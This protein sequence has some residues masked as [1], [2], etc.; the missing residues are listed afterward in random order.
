MLRPILYFAALAAFSLPILAAETPPMPE[1][2]GRNWVLQLEEGVNPEAFALEHGLEYRGPI[3]VAPGMSLFFVPARVAPARAVE[4]EATFVEDTRVTKSLPQTPKLRTVRADPSF[5]DPLY[6]EQWHWRNT[7]QGGGTRYEDANLPDAWA[8]GVTGAGVLIGIV[9]SGALYNHLDLKDRYRSD[10]SYDFRDQDNDPR[11]INSTDSSEHHGTAVAGIA[12]ATAHNNIG[13]L[14]AAPGASFAALRLIPGLIEDWQEADALGYHPQD[15]QIYNN[16]WGPDNDGAIEFDAPS[17]L[18]QEAFKKGAASGRGGLG[19][20][21]VFAGGND[22]EIGDRGDYDGYVSSIYTIGV[23]AVGADGKVAAYSEPA[24]SLLISAPSG[25]KGPGIITTSSVVPNLLN[26]HTRSFGGTSA[27][28]PIVSGVIALML[29]ANPGLTWRDVQHILVRTAS[30]VDTSSPG[31]AVNGAGHTVHHDYGHGRVDAGA[32]VALARRWVNVGPAQSYS[33]GWKRATFSGNLLSTSISFAQQLKVEHV[34]LEVIRAGT[35]DWK[36]LAITLVSPSGTRSLF[37]EPHEG[38]EDGPNSWTFMSTHHWDESLSGVWTVEISYHGS[39][40]ASNRA[41]NL[42]LTAHGT[43]DS[44]ALPVVTQ[45]EHFIR[46]ADIPL[47]VDY[48]AG[49]GD[50]LDL[51]SLDRPRFGELTPGDNQ[52]LYAMDAGHYGEDEFAFLFAGE[53]NNLVWNRFRVLNPLPAAVPDQAVTTPDQE[54]ILDL[55]ANDWDPEQQPLFLSGVSDSRVQIVGGGKVSFQG[56]DSRGWSR[57]SYT[58]TD[59]VDGQT[60]G[61]AKVIYADPTNRALEF[62]GVDD[63]VV[64]SSPPNI[65]ED[66][67]FDAWIYLE[68]WGEHETGFGRILDWGNLAIFVNGEGHAFYEDHSIVCHMIL[69]NGS[70]VA[71]NTGPLELNKW[72]HVT[73]IYDADGTPK[74]GIDGSEKSGV[75]PVGDKTSALGRIVLSPSA[76]LYIGEA[77]SGERAFN[78]RIANWR[79][80]NGIKAASVLKDS[81]SNDGL[82]IGFPFSEGSGNDATSQGAHTVTAKIDG[83]RW[84]VREYPWQPILD[85]FPGIREDPSGWWEDGM[86]GWI[87]ADDYPWVLHPEL[88]WI[89]FNSDNHNVAYLS[90]SSIGWLYAASSQYPWIY[91]WSRNEWIYLVGNWYYSPAE[92]NWFQLRS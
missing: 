87:Y 24:A 61:Y 21:Y 91:S 10:H 92:N 56:Y 44:A 17:F 37:C 41:M 59:N 14:G 75:F 65:P 3:D 1:G 39:G 88:G 53:D 57:F 67:T 58:V 27:A 40:S 7:G 45:N 13:G 35:I 9:D 2:E 76:K 84:T 16:S 34:T 33:S 71:L 51:L 54:V 20:I 78:G 25:G 38:K 12:V 68:G 4:G 42:R 23:G 49:L 50:E 22:R 5:N 86:W 70:E 80:W 47:L 19:S 66:F 83:A 74:F 72:T 69:S 55:L 82:Y 30:D 62:D 6:P 73:F 28:A 77:P 46:S 63:V 81:A 18:A 52:Y 60:T 64:V 26:N 31:W 48:L 29:E 32:A 43:A 36:D 89:Y 79:L 15:I 90:G 85:R 11:P 8:Q